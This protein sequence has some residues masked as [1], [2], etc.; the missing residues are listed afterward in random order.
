M[1]GKLFAPPK[2]FQSVCF[3]LLQPSGSSVEKGRVF[4][5]GLDFC[6]RLGLLRVRLAVFPHPLARSGFSSMNISEVPVARFMFL[7]AWSPRLGFPPSPAISSNHWCPM[8]LRSA[9]AGKDLCF[10]LVP[11]SCVLPAHVG[12]VLTAPGHRS[13]CVGLSLLLGAGMAGFHPHQPAGTEQ[14]HSA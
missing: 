6:G 11:Q 5:R 13:M 8:A 1:V 10:A 14:G 9:P 2:Q 3:A 7:Q 12:L 4:C